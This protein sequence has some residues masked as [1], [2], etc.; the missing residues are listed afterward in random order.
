MFAVRSLN[1]FSRDD[2]ACLHFV[3]TLYIYCLVGDFQRKQQQFD[4]ESSKSLETLKQRKK[5]RNCHEN[6]GELTG[7]L[8]FKGLKFW[9]VGEV[10]CVSKDTNLFSSL[11]KSFKSYSKSRYPGRDPRGRGLSAV[12][13]TGHHKP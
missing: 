1:S 2:R 7:I 6:K 10:C 3:S 11:K 12:C 8:E 9:T 4:L 13:S 5:A